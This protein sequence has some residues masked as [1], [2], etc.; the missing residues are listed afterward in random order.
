LKAQAGDVPGAR[1]LHEESLGA[2]RNLNDVDGIANGLYLLAQLDLAEQAYEAALERLTEAWSL[3]V[4]LGRVDG[5]AFAGTQ[6]GQ[7]LAVAGQRDPALEVFAGAQQAWGG[8]A[9]RVTLSRSASSSPRCVVPLGDLLVL[10]KERTG[11]H[12]GHEE[13]EERAVK[14]RRD[15]LVLPSSDV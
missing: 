2:Y 14:R 12:E 3:L 4:R 5:I 10:P 1:R 7:L 13:H 15:P 11:H 9:R 6:Y 8:W